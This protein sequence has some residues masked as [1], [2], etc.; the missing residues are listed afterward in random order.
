LSKLKLYSIPPYTPLSKKL[1]VKT[2]THGI[3]RNNEIH[4]KPGRI[5]LFLSIIYSGDKSL[6]PLI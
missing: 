3:K 2:M 4:I 5:N 1:Y 6:S